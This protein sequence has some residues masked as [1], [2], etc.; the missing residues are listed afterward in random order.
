MSVLETTNP[1]GRALEIFGAWLLALI[2]IMPLA[3]A[4]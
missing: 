1:G 4:D 3:Y 2:W